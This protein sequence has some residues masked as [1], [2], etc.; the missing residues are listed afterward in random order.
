MDNNWHEESL[1]TVATVT[2]GSSPSSS[3]YNQEGKGLPLVQGNA[4]IKQRTTVPRVFTSEITK[5][6]D[7]NDLIMTVRAPVGYMAKANQKIC[8]GR[9]VCSIKPKSVDTDFLYYY[10][11]GLENHWKTI[12]QGSTFTAVN[13]N[14][15]KDLRVKFPSRVAQERIANILSCADQKITLTDK[16]ITETKKLKKGLMQKLFSEG[17]GQQDNNKKWEPHKEFTDGKPASWLPKRLDQIASVDRGKF[18]ARP[19]NDPKYFNGAMPFVQTGN[20]TNADL[21]VEDF[22]QT[23]NE[24]GIEVS[25]VF[26]SGTILI[27]I[28]ANIG[29]VAITKFDVAC[30][31]SLVGIIAG[32]SI[33]NYWLYYALQMKKAEL[34]SKATQNAQKNINLQVLNPLTFDVPAKSEQKEISNIL[35]T[36]DRKL[37]ILKQQKLQSELLKKGLMQK[38]LTGEWEVNVNET[39]EKQATIEV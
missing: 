23:L 17:L 21:Y 32:E 22:K 26:P 37:N 35:L 29:D 2:M 20:I 34:D 3:S 25:R 11:M 18:S 13:S 36:V 7:I 15:V 1:N 8:L 4:D 28:A 14:D 16:K 30:P 19:R 39:L 6:A 12:E 27:T 9:G 33:C 5:T 38:L 10:L 24:D 31:D